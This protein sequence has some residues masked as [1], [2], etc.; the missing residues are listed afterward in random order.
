MVCLG[1]RFP[2]PGET[3][4]AA[5][6]SLRDEMARALLGEV[7]PVTVLPGGKPVFA[8]GGAQFSISHTTGCAV[9]AVSVPGPAAD[10]PYPVLDASTSR[11]SARRPRR[12][13]CGVSPSA[14]FRRS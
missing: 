8:G 11:R 12:R 5:G 1:I 2:A 10:A 6:A 13:A 9:C 4:H 3:L 14:F 7:P